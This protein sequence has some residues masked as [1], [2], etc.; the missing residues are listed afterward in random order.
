MEDYSEINRRDSYKS[1]HID[2]TSAAWCVD[3]VPNPIKDPTSRS[4]T[5]LFYRCYAG[6]LIGKE[7]L[8]C[9]DFLMRFGVLTLPG[10]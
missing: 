5:H 3:R 9:G 8:N 6:L 10:N 4:K 2:L 7:S 1:S